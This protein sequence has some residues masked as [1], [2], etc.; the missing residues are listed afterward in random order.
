MLLLTL[1]KYTT[2]MA[3]TARSSPFHDAAAA[4]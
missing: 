3:L 1:L 2:K 4:A